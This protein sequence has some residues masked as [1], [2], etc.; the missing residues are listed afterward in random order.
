MCQYQGLHYIKAYIKWEYVYLNYYL[1]SSKPSVDNYERNNFWTL[2]R[3]EN[4]M[5]KEQISFD[6]Y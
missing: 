3:K 5:E 1:S 4:V 2:V 6:H